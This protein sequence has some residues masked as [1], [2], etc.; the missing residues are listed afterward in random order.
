[1]SEIYAPFD[2]DNGPVYRF[3]VRDGDDLRDM[4]TAACECYLFD[5]DGVSYGTRPGVIISP[6][7]SGTVDVMLAGREADFG[8]S[9]VPL[10]AVLKMY[11]ATAPNRT[12]ATNVLLNASFDTATGT[13][14]S[15]IADNW[16]QSSSG[17]TFD[18]SDNDAA[19]SSIFGTNQS[20]TNPTGNFL[21][22]DVAATPALGDRW[23]FGCWVRGSG[24]SGVEDDFNS[25]AMSGIGG[26]QEDIVVRLPVG[27]FD[28]RFFQDELLVAQASHTTMRMS[29]FALSTHT[30]SW[31]FDEAFM[32]AGRW[33]VRH[34][35]EPL[36]LKVKRTTRIP[37]ASNQIAGFGSFERDANSDGIPD[38]FTKIGTGG[39][40]T[41]NKDPA[42]V[43][44]ESASLKV[45]L[46]DQSGM[47]LKLPWPGKYRVGDTWRASVMEKTVGTLGA[48]AG[49]GGF[50]IALR[51]ETF[52]AAPVISA[53]TNLSATAASFTDHS[54]SLAI[55]TAERSK[56]VI[57]I[58]LNGKTGTLYLD[59]VRLERTVA[60]P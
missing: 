33:I 4:A 20:V 59:D 5:R 21:F 54:A 27:E 52:D 43:S 16:S 45:A 41:L 42:H 40:F 3:P 46:T 28:W 17:G 6:K 35:S 32:F 2:G 15:R 38:G 56:L 36:E 1:M 8:G 7:S 9:P 12:P 47:M 53:S 26:V 19:P 51:T 25:I 39:T 30:G 22:Q 23:S 34:S 29:L 37:K 60:G 48:G 44:H 11:Y 18:N 50:S 55:T 58:N 31:R 57:E 10:W 13:S 49:T 14:P 24:I